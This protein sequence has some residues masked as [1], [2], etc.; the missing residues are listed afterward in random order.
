MAMIKY[1][2]LAAF[3]TKFVSALF[4]NDLIEYKCICC[5]KNYKKKGDENLKKLFFNTY[6]FSNCDMKNLFYYCKK[7][8]ALIKI[9]M[10]GK[11]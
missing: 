11:N 7:V 5:N 9:W 6:H 1:V 2:K 8:F 3:N 4:V 10:I